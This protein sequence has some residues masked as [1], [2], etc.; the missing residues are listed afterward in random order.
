MFQLFRMWLGITESLFRNTALLEEAIDTAIN[1]NTFRGDDLEFT[2]AA[3]VWSQR[4]SLGHFDAY[5]EKVEGIKKYFGARFP[6]A[7]KM[8]NEMIKAI[9]EKSGGK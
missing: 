1:D 8:G 7:T 5:K 2:F 4:V 6:E 9:L 3:R